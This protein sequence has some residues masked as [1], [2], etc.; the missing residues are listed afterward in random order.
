MAKSSRTPQ[1]ILRKLAE[2]PDETVRYC[3]Y[4][5]PA[6]ADWVNDY[7]TLHNLFITEHIDFGIDIC[8]TDS[9]YD[10]TNPEVIIE[11]CEQVLSDMRAGIND[12]YVRKLPY[13]A[14]ED[15]NCPGDCAT[16]GIDFSYLES[17]CY[18]VANK[19]E[20]AL[21]KIGCEILSSDFY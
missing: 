20:R 2:H 10:G 5:N 11:V 13:D 12:C 8:Y 18:V 17:S 15:E 19:L 16:I 6:A 9:M 4:K 7:P 14:Y 1:D 21:E 3:V